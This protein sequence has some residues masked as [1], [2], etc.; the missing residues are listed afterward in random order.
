MI[1]TR[2]VFI[3][4]HCDDELFCLP[5]LLEKNSVNTI[6][7]LTTLDKNNAEPSKVNIRMQEALKANK[8]LSK[9][10][11]I[12]TIFYNEGI[13]DGTI[14]T[15]FYRNHF[16]QLTRF[17]LDE[18][19]DEL[20]T[21]S[22]EAGHQ[23]H[24]SAYLITRLISENEQ[25][26]LRCFSGYRASTLFPRLFTVLRPISFSNKIDFNRILITLIAVRLMIIYRSQAKTWIGLAPVLLIKYI[27]FPFWEAK[28][29]TPLGYQSIRDCFYENRGRAKQHEV[30]KSHQ[31]FITQ[32]STKRF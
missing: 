14:H 7:F 29:E 2:R 3:F 13:Y 19:P 15:D 12:K 9:A 32:F 25:L 24:D 18:K 26:K 8:F 6:V 1:K 28:C 16:K 4:A 23:D 10:T 30:M 20:V 5:L 11:T 17:V 21:L 27:L 31:R 22:Y